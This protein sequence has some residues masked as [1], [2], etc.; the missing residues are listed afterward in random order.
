MVLFVASV[1]MKIVHHR[2]N[3]RPYAP[4]AEG[5][6]LTRAVGFLAAGTSVYRAAWLVARERAMP[7]LAASETPP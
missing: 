4:V 6:N 3:E 5:L 2:G 1:V 7:L